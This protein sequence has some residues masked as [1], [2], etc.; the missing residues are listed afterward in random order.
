ML[1]KIKM[2]ITQS[3]LFRYQHFGNA[4]YAGFLVFQSFQMPV[5]SKKKIKME[6]IL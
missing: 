4:D 2:N 6:L 5:N 3:K 1:I